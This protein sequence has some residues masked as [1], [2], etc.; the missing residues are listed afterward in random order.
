MAL[1]TATAT[2][3]AAETAIESAAV[4]AAKVIEAS[5][6][7]AAIEAAILIDVAT[8]IAEVRIAR[9]RETTVA[10]TNGWAISRA[11]GAV[12]TAKVIEAAPEGIETAADESAATASTLRRRHT[13]GQG[14]HA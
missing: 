11:V 7:S 12:S 6:E 1:V 2:E 4:S 3:S 14:N 13:R 8:A 5:A 9:A 10:N